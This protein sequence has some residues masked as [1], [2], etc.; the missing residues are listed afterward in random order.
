MRKGF[1]FYIYNSK[2]TVFTIQDISLLLM[3]NNFNSLKSK[4]HYHIKKGVLKSVRRGIYVKPEYEVYE[5][6][7][8][9]YTPSYISL[10][11]VLQKEG[12]IFQYYDTVFTVSYLSRNLIVDGHNISLKK[13]KNS[14]LLN[15]AGVIQKENYAIATTERAFLD[16]LYLYRNYH[17]DN[18]DLL[19]RD[20][21]SGIL[22]VY[23]SRT[24]EEKVKKILDNA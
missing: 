2:K 16:T 15:S 3:E 19:N 12:V 22:R 9:I 14:I 13:I 20:K 24:L 4:I 6:A 23:N 11:T 7:T 5:L 8:R 17:F 18:I 1:I 10:E 21:I